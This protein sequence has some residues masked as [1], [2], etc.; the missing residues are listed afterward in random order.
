M[1]VRGG[2]TLRISCWGPFIC[3]CEAVVPQEKF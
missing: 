1:F 2:R 3:V